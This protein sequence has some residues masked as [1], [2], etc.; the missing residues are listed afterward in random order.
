MVFGKGTGFAASLD[1]SVLDGSNGFRLD[2]IENGD[3]FGFSVGTAGDVNGDG[4]NDILVGAYGASQSDVINAGKT[5]LIFGTPRLSTLFGNLRRA[6]TPST[7]TIS[8]PRQKKPSRAMGW[9]YCRIFLGMGMAH[10]W[11]RLRTMH[12]RNW[13]T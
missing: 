12:T 1:L 2:G 9:N 6:D 3:G 13:T 4:F 5:Y 11:V 8:W 10:W 7:S